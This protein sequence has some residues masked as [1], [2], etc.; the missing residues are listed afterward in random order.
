[1]RWSPIL[2]IPYQ[3]P[4]HRSESINIGALYDLMY[5]LEDREVVDINSEYLGND[6]ELAPK[7][8]YLGKITNKTYDELPTRQAVLDRFGLHD[9]PYILISLG[10]NE[11]SGILCM[12]LIHALTAAG[13]AQRNRIV[14]IID[15]YMDTNA[16]NALK[17]D[18][19]GHGVKLLPFIPDLVDLI[20]HAEL[21]IARAGYNTVNEI[22]LTGTPAMLIPESHGSGE[23]EQRAAALCEGFIRVV[24]EDDALKGRIEEPLRELHEG[25]RGTPVKFDKY[26]IG[27]R[28]IDDLEQWHASRYENGIPD[29]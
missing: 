12:R 2:R 18:C 22:L 17:V 8:H 6:P 4:R 13:F 24:S 10:R 14:M 23:Q 15:P 28:I 1:M 9:Q 27:R 11:H 20:R 16:A 29:R 21:V 7:I 3:N 25:G 26:A 19:E 5:V